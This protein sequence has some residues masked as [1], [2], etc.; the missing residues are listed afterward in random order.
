MSSPLF[1]IDSLKCFSYGEKLF[2]QKNISLLLQKHVTSIFQSK[3]CEIVKNYRLPLNPNIFL[4]FCWF[5]LTILLTSIK[6][7]CPFFQMVGAVMTAWKFTK[8][9]GLIFTETYRQFMIQFSHFSN[10]VRPTT[11]GSIRVIPKI[12]LLASWSLEIYN[13]LS[14][15]WSSSFMTSKEWYLYRIIGFKSSNISIEKFLNI[16][17]SE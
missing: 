3:N 13:N 7:S 6:Q 10:L 14:L 11:L 15:V 5:L 2:L 16:G 8:Y 9:S 4:T 1:Y 12:C 17:L